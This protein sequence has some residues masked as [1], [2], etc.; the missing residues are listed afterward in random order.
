[1]RRRLR[2]QCSHRRRNRRAERETEFNP[3]GL[4]ESSRSY[5]NIMDPVLKTAAGNPE[6]QDRGVTLRNAAG[7]VLAVADGAGGLSGGTE[8]ALM[9]I[10]LVREHA[11]RLLDS[12]ACAAVLREMDQRI[13]ADAKAGETTCVI[14]VLTVDQIL[15]ASV[16]DSCAW[17]IGPTEITNLTLAQ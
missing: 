5:R 14:A 9:A 6:N 2:H 8:A 13:A 1:M 12:A 4:A 10:R 7:W 17:M 16:G 15:G 11:E 3:C